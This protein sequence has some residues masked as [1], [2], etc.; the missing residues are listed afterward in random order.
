MLFRRVKDKRAKRVSENGNEEAP[1]HLTSKQ[2]MTNMCQSSKSQYQSVRFEKECLKWASLLLK[3]GSE[4]L[5]DSDV[6]HRKGNV[7]YWARD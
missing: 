7:Y 1:L 6:A 2:E 4:R 3:N 5:S